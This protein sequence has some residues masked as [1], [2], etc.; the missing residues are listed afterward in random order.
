MAS[1]SI[2]ADRFESGALSARS[3]SVTDSGDL[4]VSTS[5]ALVGS[6]G[7]QVDIA[8]YLTDDRPSAET[9]YRARF[10]FY[11]NS[12]LMTNSDAHYIFYGYSGAS[13]VVLGLQF[14]RS[15]GAYQ[16]QAAL[17]NDS[18]SWTNSGRFTLSDTPH[19]IEFDWR[20]STAAG[21]NNGRLTL[22][23]DGTQRAD[24][25]GVDNDTRRIDRV[26]LGAVSAIDKG[27]RGRYSF[28][29]FVSRR[30]TYIGP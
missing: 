23:I 17:L 9:R 7:L 18:T 12:M 4:C 14:R 6:Y 24:L 11:S 27:T 28:D 19:V 1:D 5:A 29:A 3:A 26:R 15:S 21:A 30:T 10:Y 22:W 8:I 20:A 13:T 16:L 2:F 25:I